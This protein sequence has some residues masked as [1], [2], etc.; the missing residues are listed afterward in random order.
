M[1]HLTDDEFETI[2]RKL[3]PITRIVY[4][5]PSL[6]WNQMRAKVNE[7]WLLYFMGTQYQDKFCTEYIEQLTN[8]I[9]DKLDDYLLTKHEDFI[10]SGVSDCP[11]LSSKHPP[12]E[13]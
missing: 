1:K 9:Q 8:V 5:D 6:T 12:H 10:R 13:Q 4:G 3:T 7:L 2:I 11:L